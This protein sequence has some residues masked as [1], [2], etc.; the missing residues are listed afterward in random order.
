MLQDIVPFFPHKIILKLVFPVLG[1]SLLPSACCAEQVRPRI[2]FGHTDALG[3]WKHMTLVKILPQA[4]WE[5]RWSRRWIWDLGSLPSP[6]MLKP[7]LLSLSDV[8]SV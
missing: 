3:I 7:V 5:R 6:V 1:T 2:A 8:T 4:P